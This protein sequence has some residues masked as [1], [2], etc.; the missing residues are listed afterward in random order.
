VKIRRAVIAL[1]AGAAS[2]AKLA[3]A[4]RPAQHVSGAEVRGESASC[5]NAAEPVEAL[6]NLGE[7]RSLFI[8]ALDVEK[9]VAEVDSCASQFGRVLDCRTDETPPLFEAG[10]LVLP[11]LG[12]ARA[13]EQ[14]RVKS[15]NDLAAVVERPAEW[16]RMP[17]CAVL[18]VGAIDG[19]ARHDHARRDCHVNLAPA[20]RE[21]KGSALVY[22]AVAARQF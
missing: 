8:V 17:E 16:V 22:A 11:I 4:C 1:D 3:V 15:L 6:Q 2:G 5:V 14:D 20:E 18:R 7:R 12:Q 19:D 10:L 9:Q 21:S 13:A